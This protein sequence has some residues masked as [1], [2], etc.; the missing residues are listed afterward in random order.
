MEVSKHSTFYWWKFTCYYS[1]GIVLGVSFL[2][3]DYDGKFE[4]AGPF[5]E[6][7]SPS[8]LKERGIKGVR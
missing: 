6:Y 2:S 4:G 8:P 5:K 1:T 3:T 7:P